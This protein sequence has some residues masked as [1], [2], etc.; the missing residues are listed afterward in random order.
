MLAA[1]QD[2]A[3]MVLRPRTQRTAWT[4]DPVEPE[5]IIQQWAAVW[6][7]PKPVA[8]PAARLAPVCPAELQQGLILRRTC[9]QTLVCGQQLTAFWCILVEIIV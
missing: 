4:L 1:Y 7:G 5:L 9:E 6:S 2:T 8:K 3:I